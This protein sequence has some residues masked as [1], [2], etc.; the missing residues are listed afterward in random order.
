MADSGPQPDLEQIRTN[1]I[2]SSL[3]DAILRSLERSDNRATRLENSVTRIETRVDQ[4]ENNVT[5]IQTQVNQMEIQLDVL[6]QQ[7]AQRY[8]RVEGRIDTLE[9]Q[10]QA[11]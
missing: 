11:R 8:N 5:Q 1:P 4:I 2:L 9:T 7:T 3:F 10:L 6:K